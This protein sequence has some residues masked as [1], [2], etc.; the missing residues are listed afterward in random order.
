MW[1]EQW[2]EFLSFPD[3]REGSSRLSSSP[4][5]QH[6][7]RSH[8]LFKSI[9]T[10]CWI[11]LRD[12]IGLDWVMWIQA[13]SNAAAPSTH[14]SKKNEQHGSMNALIFPA[15]SALMTWS[16]MMNCSLVAGKGLRSHPSKSDIVMWIKNVYI[17][18]PAVFTP[19]AGCWRRRAA[20]QP[21]SL[22]SLI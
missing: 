7:Q 3:K 11:S 20:G 5:C 2:T 22:N 1:R 10:I 9:R 13:Q 6:P 4:T 12:V 16:D 18:N 15:I 21:S 8:S 14:S 17:L 19:A